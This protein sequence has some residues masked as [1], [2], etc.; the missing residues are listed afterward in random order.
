MKEETL[1]CLIPC[2]QCLF[3]TIKGL[4]KLA[5]RIQELWMNKTRG[6]KHIDVLRDGAMK[7]YIIDIRL[8]EGPLLG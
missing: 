7:K 3:E 8:V 5:N 2:S 1:E 4:A 6:M